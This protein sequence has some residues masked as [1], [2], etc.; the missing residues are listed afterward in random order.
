[1]DTSTHDLPALFKQLGLP[2]SRADIN[3]FLQ[4]HR[5]EQGVALA[6]ADFWSHAQRQFLRE[7]WQADADWSGAIDELAA[8]LR[9]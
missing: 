5:L 4:N 8:R 7:G 1:M 6:D 2:D 3:Q 9:H